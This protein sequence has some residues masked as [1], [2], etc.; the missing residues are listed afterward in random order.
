MTFLKYFSYGKGV[1]GRAIDAR[2]SMKLLSLSLFCVYVLFDVDSR[3]ALCRGWDARAIAFTRRR[4]SFKLRLP[5]RFLLFALSLSLC[6]SRASFASSLSA[7]YFCISERMGN[8]TSQSH[9]VVNVCKA[10][11]LFVF[12][13]VSLFRNGEGPFYLPRASLSLQHLVDIPSHSPGSDGPHLP[14]GSPSS[15]LDMELV[16]MGDGYNGASPPRPS[17][18]VGSPALPLEPHGWPTLREFP[19]WYWKRLTGWDQSLD[20]YFFRPHYEQLIALLFAAA[21]LVV[22]GALQHYLFIP[23]VDGSLAIFVPA[24]GAT[25]TCIF[26][27]PKHPVSQPRNIIIGHVSAGVIGISLMNL[28][29]LMPQQPYGVDLAGAIGVGLHQIVM[30]FTNTLHPPASAT[31]VSAV[32]ASYESFYNDKGFIYCV[33][34]CITGPILIIIL[35]ILLNNLVPSRSPYPVYW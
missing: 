20:V 17:S 33:T 22:L 8:V 29:L 18:P 21:T 11:S 15:P 3:V 7:V 9:L 1:H 32:H 23:L 24:I 13:S 19:K 35:A 28:F 4:G 6:V 14:Y 26:G 12:C 25:V 30:I 16:A 31:V 27:A 5:Q 2:L 10:F 34:P